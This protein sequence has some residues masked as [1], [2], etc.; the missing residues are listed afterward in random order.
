MEDGL[1]KVV[2][3]MDDTPA[4][5][6][7]IMSGD[8]ISAV[9][10]IEVQGLTLEQAVKKMKGPI[11]YQ[12][13]PEDHAQ[14]RGAADRDFGRARSHPGAAGALPHQGRRHRLYPHHLI[15]RTDHR[16]LAKSHRR[17]IEADPAGETGRLCRRPAQQPR[18]LARSGGLG[19][20]CV[21]GARR[22]G[23]DARPRRRRNPALHRADRRPDQGQAAGRPDQRRIGFRCPRSW[24]ARCTI[25]SAQR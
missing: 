24:P 9:D 8:L 10:G 14:G 6:A 21:H 5:K 11:R 17:H 18:R 2:A 12:D 19:I 3:P 23:L 25:T 4:A 20:E 1:V 7:G 16:R 13:P 22:G 15:Q